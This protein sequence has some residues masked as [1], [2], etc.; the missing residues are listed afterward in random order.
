MALQIKKF[1]AP[2]LQEA[3]ER[4]RDELGDDAIIL[5]TDPVRTNGA[6]S[7]D[8][9]E[10]TAAIDRAEAPQ[11]RFH[12]TVSEAASERPSAPAAAKS[13]LSALLSGAKFGFNKKASVPKKTATPALPA[14]PTPVKPTVIETVTEVKPSMGQIYAMK[15]FIEPLQMEVESLKNEL[16]KSAP[17]AKKFK[18]PLEE[19]VQ[20]L[21]SELRSFITERRFDQSNLPVYFRELLQF[22]KEKGVTEKQIYNLFAEIENWGDTLS[23]VSSP[24]ESASHLNQFLSGAIQEANVFEKNEQRIVVLVGPTGVGKTTTLAKMAAYE[25]LRLK[26]SVAFITADDFKI[27]GTDQLAHYARILEVPF[28]K[29]R[30]DV[31][32]EDQCKYFEGVQTIFVDT[33]GVSFRDETRMDALRKT[34]QFK[35]PAFASKVETH[36]VLPVSVSSHD[37]ND[38]I[39]AYNSLKPKYLAFTKW[40]ETDHWGGMLSAIL[41]SRK[42]VSFIS[43]GQSVP[44]DF[45]LFS[46]DSFIQ[47]VTNSTGERG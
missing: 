26:R 8:K 33:Y 16:K 45:A 5:Q 39:A 46:K 22:W 23:D 14:A 17:K 25:K 11:A 21:R 3:I 41:A 1:R 36:L 37:V 29:Y 24:V 20:K 44:D 47:T 18:D 2:T 9:I 42:P 31:S 27:G 15:T 7:R 12:A 34:L 32:L 6:F 43:N 38:Y 35:D 13:G 30:A 10:V 40:D 19:E 4:V 28:Q